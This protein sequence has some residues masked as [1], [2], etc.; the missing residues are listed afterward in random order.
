MSINAQMGPSGN[1][2]KLTPDT[3]TIAATRSLWVGTAGP[4]TMVSASGQTLTD[5]PLEK[6]LNPLRVTRISSATAS[7]IWAMY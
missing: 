7:D 6:G 3:G 4:A 5:F 2:V 1:V